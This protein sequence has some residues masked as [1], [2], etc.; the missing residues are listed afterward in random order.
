MFLSVTVYPPSSTVSMDSGKKSKS[1][2][3]AIGAVTIE[4]WSKGAVAFS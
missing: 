4:F 2:V 1:F 3:P